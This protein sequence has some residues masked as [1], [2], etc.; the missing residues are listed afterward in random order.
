MKR[1][2]NLQVWIALSFLAHTLPAQ[3]DPGASLTTTNRE[4]TTHFVD[5]V[6]AATGPAT[7][8]ALGDSVSQSNWRSFASY[9]ANS[10]QPA[11]A[12]RRPTTPRSPN[13]LTVP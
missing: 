7:V 5:V 11:T 2:F 8:L 12:S 10:G 1:F 9:R 6:N 4:V 3:T 13:L